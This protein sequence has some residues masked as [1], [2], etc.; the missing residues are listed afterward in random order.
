[1]QDL[2]INGVEKS[3]TQIEWHGI[4]FDE[5]GVE[6]SPHTLPTSDFYS[7]FYEELFNRYKNFESLPQSW[8]TVKY[9]TALCIVKELSNHQRILSYGCGIGY[10]ETIL[11]GINPNLAIDAFD[12]SENASK[13]ISKNLLKINYT[14]NLSADKKYDL[15]YACQLLYALSYKDCVELIRLLSGHLKPNGKILLINTSINSDEN[16]EI[17]MYGGL[18]NKIRKI[19]R[20]I[21]KKIHPILNIHKEQFWVWQRDNKKYCE[22]SIEANMSVSKCYHAANQSFILLTK[23]LV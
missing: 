5:L 6:I 10:I 15:I 7:N 11:A 19:L 16:G 17:S 8:L 23:K 22:M 21:Y 3:F 2:R 1:M 13:W 18:K 12:F 4:Y 20:P 9:K 14:N